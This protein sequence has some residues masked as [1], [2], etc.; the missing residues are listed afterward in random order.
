VTPQGTISTVAGNGSQGFSGDGGPAVAAVLNHP[1]GV[2]VD[3]SG[4][5]FI[6]DFYNNRIRE[7]T[8]QGT[9]TTVA[10][11]AALSNNCDGCP[12][13]SAVLNHPT[14]IAVDALGDLFIGDYGNELIRKVTP[15]GT[16]ITVAGNSS[17]G[18]SGD[19]GPAVAAQ[20]GGPQGVAVDASG[21]LFIADSSNNRIR[22]LAPFIF[23]VGCV[24]SVDQSAQSFE[25]AGGT[26][27]DIKQLTHFTGP[28]SFQTPWASL[29]S[30][31]PD[32]KRIL[33][34]TQIPTG[35]GGASLTTVWTVNADGQQLRSLPID[36]N[37]QIVVFSR[38]GTL[39]A[40]NIERQ[41]HVMKVDTGEDRQF[42]DFNYSALPGAAMEFAP[43][44]SALYFLLGQPGGNGSINALPIGSAISS[45][46]LRSG[47]LRSV[48]A[49]RTMSSSGIVESVTDFSKDLTPGGLVTVYGTN[50]TG[51]TLGVAPAF[52]LPATIA[53]VSLLINGKPAPLLATTPYQ[54]NAAIPMDAPLG[55]ATFQV[56]F[57]DGTTTQSWMANVVAQSPYCKWV[58]HAGSGIAVDQAHPADPGEVLETYGVGGG[59]TNPPIAAGQPAPVS[60]LAAWSGMLRVAL[61]YGVDDATVLWAGAAPGTVGLYQVNIQ[62]PQQI[63]RTQFIPPLSVQW[64]GGGVN[65]PGC[66]VPVR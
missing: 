21:N 36:P 38:D 65:N 59:V 17:Q 28:I 42:A 33:F 19:G 58:L 51:D 26:N 47:S 25:A 63:P 64:L 43:D 15:Q 7:V 37:V 46:D 12:A 41:I 1:T 49:P 23:T 48:Y 34:V 60:P 62:L 5:L 8:P 56:R 54:V 50:L 55:Q 66:L 14:G 6:A 16:I 45:I 10:G 32:G 9:I 35:A 44:N 24:Y 57:A 31:T 22:K 61:G 13:T 29:A 4:N 39:V 30:I 53:G 20:L 18:Y 3:A 27:S 40:W 2:A 11:S 52:P